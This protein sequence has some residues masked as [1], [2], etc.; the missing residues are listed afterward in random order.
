MPLARPA[1]PAPNDRGDIILGWLTKIT[2][3][4][5]VA[6]IFLFDAISVGTTAMS[7]TDQ[8]GIAAREASE[9]WQQTGSIQRAYDAAA[10]AAVEQNPANEVAAGSF[11]IDAD[12]TVH[13]RIS[14]TASSLLLF[15]W[16]KTAGWAEL[17]REARG[18][19]VG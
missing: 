10:A 4:L 18:R 1:C 2:I 19:S 8:G 3:I 14:R 13:L 15:R 17:D 16:D 9:V 7:L 6:G 11:R 5:G 12:N